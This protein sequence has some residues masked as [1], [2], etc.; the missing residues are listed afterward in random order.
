MKHIIKIISTLYLCSAL[1]TTPQKATAQISV[2]LQVFYDQLSP[3]GQWV[4]Y[5]QYGYAWIPSLDETFMP[6][7]TDGHWVLTDYGWTW[8]SDYD[9]G[10]AAFHY[11]RWQYDPYY[12][13]IWIPDTMWG[14]AWVAWRQSSGYYGWAP[15]GPGLDISVNFGDYDIP[16]ERWV[17]VR[18]VDIVRP[19]VR[20]YYVNRTE[21]VTIIKKTTVIKNTYVDRS[22]NITY[23]A[24]P[25][26][27]EVQKV[28]GKPVKP[29]AI[30]ESNKPEQ[31]VNNDKLVI[32]KPQVKKE[33]NS[34]KKPAPPKVVA[35]KDVKKRVPRRENANVPGNNQQQE[36]NNR[37][38][39]RS[40]SDNNRAIQQQQ[41][42]NQNKN[43][44]DSGNNKVNRQQEEKNPQN[45]NRA[46]SNNNRPNQQ[47]ERKPQNINPSN[48][49]P[50]QQPERKPENINPQNNKPSQEQ[51]KPNM[52]PQNMKDT[53]LNKNLHQPQQKPKPKPVPQK[54]NK[55]QPD[56][57]RRPH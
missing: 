52:K 13:W 30:E 9:W 41:K 39:N 4:D 29:V 36:K 40:D 50:N 49:K 45:I 23:V 22:R 47:Q 34:G 25:D 17:F 48:N 2:S 54:P 24:G 12:G 15:L 21:N 37:N 43:R 3:Y 33:D 19:D 35:L 18:D 16:P 32:Y 27:N 56:T 20:R 53:S 10:W 7:A 26:K 38:I 8:V 55:P 6:Y 5:P 31:K 11:G 46:D 51:A 57:A 14:P 42:V 1:T 28:T 44:L